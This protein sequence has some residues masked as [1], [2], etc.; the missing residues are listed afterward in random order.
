[1][2][3]ISLKTE[4]KRKNLKKL[5]AIWGK[6]LIMKYGSRFYSERY[7]TGEMKKSHQKVEIST[8]MRVHNIPVIPMVP[9]LDINKETSNVI[10]VPLFIR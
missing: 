7:F 2:G 6:F 9:I 3:N 8:E 1:M 5:L 10:E 4:K